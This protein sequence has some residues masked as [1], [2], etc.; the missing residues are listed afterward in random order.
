MP[1]RGLCR[2][3]ISH[4]RDRCGMFARGQ[5]PSALESTLRPD[6]R[7]HPHMKH[8]PPPRQM[9]GEPGREGEP[10]RK[11]LTL[12]QWLVILATL[13]SALLVPFLLVMWL[14]RG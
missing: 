4:M 10:A 7:R 5:K 8:F 14:E 12:Q 6:R 1:C 2:T 3:P 9:S 13:L 11:R